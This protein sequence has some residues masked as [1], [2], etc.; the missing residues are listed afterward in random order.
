M[1]WVRDNTGCF[2]ERP[3]YL[4]AELDYECEK[5]IVE[6]AQRIHGGLTFP[7]STDTLTKLIE[8][9]ASDLDLYAD[10]SAEP[11]EA[12]GV[13]DFYP[14]AK[15]RVRIAKELMEQDWREHRL[16][17]TLTHEYGHVKF[18]AP[19]WDLHGA[20]HSMFPEITDKPSPKCHRDTILDAPS[21]NWME[22]QAGYA[23]GALLMPVTTIKKLVSEFFLAHDI[24]GSL[25]LGS[26][27][28]AA[29]QASIM[30][31]FD[32]SQEAAKVRLLQ[33][34]Y[35]ARDSMSPSLFE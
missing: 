9:D 13:T 21:S 18:H 6:F 14:G 22:W 12:Q 16:R 2:P 11:G 7:I 10:L 17:T 8:R 25:S 3:H 5:T 34:G 15:P 4:P 32:V 26:S 29:L 33:L 1:K 19:L 24:Y 23:C 30:R 28:A 27:N 31:T 20:S 35:L